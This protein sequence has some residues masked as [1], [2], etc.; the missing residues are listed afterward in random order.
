MSTEEHPHT[1][2]RPYRKRIRARQEEETRRRIAV[3]AMELHGSVGPART[4]MSAVAERA[5]VQRT[6]LYRHFPDEASLFGACSA[7]WATLHPAPD[8]AAWRAEP[9]P[10]V[11]LRVALRDLY[12]WYASDER[13]FANIQRDA[14]LV[15]AVEMMVEATAEQM[16]EYAEIICRGRPERG[17]PRRRVRAAIAHVISFA[18][19]RALVNEG[20]LE[21]REAVEVAAAMAEAAGQV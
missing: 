3:A 18:A 14:A 1:G 5:G 21:R 12:G 16:G 7:H 17:A 13:M 20:G 9:E 2:V 15:P 11:R 6:T 8:P 10:A 19:Y 4:T